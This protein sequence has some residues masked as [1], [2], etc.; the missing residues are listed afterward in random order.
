MC[1]IDENFRRNFVNGLT[2]K[3]RSK[4]YAYEIPTRMIKN[5]D[6]VLLACKNVY[7]SGIIF[8]Q[9]G[10][11]AKRKG[12]P[13]IESILS[14]LAHKLHSYFLN[15]ENASISQKQFNKF[16]TDWCNSFLK[17]VNS[18][19]ASVRY[20]P[21]F[22]GSSQKMINMVFKY[23]A[24]YEDY[25][26]FNNHFKWCHMPIDTVILRWLKD[27]YKISD[28][29]YYV[30]INSNGKEELSARY[31]NKAWT[32]FDINLYE[33]ISSLI[34]DKVKSDADFNNYS[35]LGVEFSIWA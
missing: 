16:H 32:Q 23:L 31:K 7:N 11:A 8:P 35:I 2:T 20:E 18:A 27:R 17:D 14:N 13:N 29:Y 26:R 10:K 15:E 22:Y 6:H 1:I 33:D 19:R 25:T 3:R 28:I 21:I 12:T 24:C 5:Y 9:S 4:S 34:F 30:Y